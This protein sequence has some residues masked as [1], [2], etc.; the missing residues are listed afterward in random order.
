MDKRWL[1]AA[2]RLGIALLFCPSVVLNAAEL[3]APF[4]DTGYFLY[5]TAIDPMSGQVVQEQ[6]FRFEVGIGGGHQ[7]GLTGHEGGLFLGLEILTERRT[8][9]I[10]DLS[11]I[12][13][14][15]TQAILRIWGW[16]PNPVIG[17]SGVYASADVEETYRIYQVDSHDPAT[18]LNAPFNDVQNHTL[19]KPIWQD[20]G[21]GAI[22]G[23]RSFTSADNLPP[24]FMPSPTSTDPNLDC[25]DPLNGPCGRWYDIA[26]NGA[27][28]EELSQTGGQIIFGGALDF[29][30]AVGG[31]LFGGNWSDLP[32]SSSLHPD[33]ITPAP[34]L[35][36]TTR[37]AGGVDVPIPL[38]AGLSLAFVLGGMARRQLGRRSV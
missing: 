3:E 15:V 24:G 9:L 17:G 25:S 38:W 20:L 28:L 21:D 10:F 11:N 5:R 14:Q 34:Q 26:L 7:I 12:D 33:W 35:I 13:G 30:N 23:A 27:A 31:Q 36:L 22:Y 1:K 16:G 29:T 8:Y 4:V 19:D 32:P 2:H 18:I 6:S 37:P